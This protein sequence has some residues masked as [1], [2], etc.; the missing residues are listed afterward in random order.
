MINFC[1]YCLM[2]LLVLLML[3]MSLSCD[4]CCLCCLYVFVHTYTSMLVPTRTLNARSFLPTY[5]HADEMCLLFVLACRSLYPHERL[6][7][8][9]AT[10]VYTHIM[11]PN[12]SYSRS[13]LVRIYIY[14]HTYIY[15]IY[16]YIPVHLP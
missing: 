1:Q 12:H 7:I 11:S 16:L 14:I 3:A 10:T 5:M 6:L 2:F 13:S 8:L 15:E 9:L 4:D